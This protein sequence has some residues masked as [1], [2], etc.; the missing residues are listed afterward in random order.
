MS[1]NGL[2]VKNTCGSKQ[3]ATCVY[4]EGEVPAFSSLTEGECITL[5]DTNLDIYNILEGIK[6]EL[7]FTSL[8]GAC[9]TY[10]NTNPSLLQVLTAQQSKICQLE[11]SITSLNGSIATMQQQIAELQTNTCP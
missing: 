6:S 8:I 7:N 11:A 10:P 9:I 1:C 4:Y 3:Y 2:T 5:H